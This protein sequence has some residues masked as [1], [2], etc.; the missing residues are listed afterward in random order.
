MSANDDTPATGSPTPIGRGRSDCTIALAL[1]V[2]MVLV[3]L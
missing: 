1:G 3:A 2:V